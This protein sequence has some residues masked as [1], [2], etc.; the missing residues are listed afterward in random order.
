MTS[1]IVPMNSITGFERSAELGD[2]K[3][4][5]FDQGVDQ[6][7]KLDNNL[8]AETLKEIQSLDAPAPSHASGI[9]NVLSQG[10]MDAARLGHEVGRMKH[11]F[12]LGRNDDLHGT[13]IAARKAGISNKLVGAVRGKLLE[14]FQELWRINV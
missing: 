2:A 9:G 4:L 5:A 3:K 13:L 11:D 10:V 14:A 12:A 8:F 6:S 1:P 7:V